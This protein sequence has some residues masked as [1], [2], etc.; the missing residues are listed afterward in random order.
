MN[1]KYDLST[2][3]MGRLEVGTLIGV[4]T[5]TVPAAF[6]LIL[7]IHHD[8]SLLHDIHVELRRATSTVTGPDGQKQVTL[9][10]PAL[11]DSCPLLNSAWQETLRLH[12]KGAST[13]LVVEDTLLNE[14]WLL[15]KG[16][17]VMIPQGAMHTDPAA[18]GDDSAEFQPR[19]FL[20]QEGVRRVQAASYRPFGGGSTICPGRF[21]VT[22]EV[23]ML[24]AM[25]V[26]RYEVEPVEGEWKLPRPVQRSLAQ[27][28]F[29]PE[30]D[31]RVKM[32]LREGMRGT[33]WQFSF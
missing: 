4:L 24:A 12:A 8:P 26:L 19:R 18:W 21:F 5:N 6:Y 1:K 28:V 32:S 2:A 29:P 13:R 25:L 3:N 7:R 15:K 30:G 14:R 20:R 22:M 17:V 16:C 31:V 11:R 33:D 23:L 9:R 10:V 27:N